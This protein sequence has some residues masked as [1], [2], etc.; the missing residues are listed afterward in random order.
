M[1]ILAK[2][3]VV[4]LFGAACAACSNN[5]TPPPTTSVPAA[6]SATPPAASAIPMQAPTA[7]ST[8]TTQV[9]PIPARAPSLAMILQRPAFAKA[10]ADMD[11]T[12]ALPEWAKGSDDPTPSTRVQV[13]GRTMWLSHVCEA[14]DCQGGQLFLLTDP[15][16]HA[17]RG[18]L[19]EAAGGSGDSVRKLTWLGKPDA[20]ARAFLEAQVATRD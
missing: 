18:L 2:L 5:N 6:P 17:M 14:G 12:S 16:R 20:A 1:N 4:A 15:A 10:F 8:A 9:L 3:F 19:V 11:G 13:E 7:G